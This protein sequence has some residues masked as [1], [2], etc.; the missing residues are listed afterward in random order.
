[1]HDHCLLDCLQLFSQ[2]AVFYWD[3][4]DTTVSSPMVDWSPLYK[5]LIKKMPYRF[6]YSLSDRGI[7]LIWGSCFQI[8]L[9]WIKLT[10]IKIKL[11][12]N[13]KQLFYDKNNLSYRAPEL[14]LKVDKQV[15]DV[16]RQ[17]KGFWDSD[18]ISF[19][20]LGN[21]ND[22]HFICA[23]FCVVLCF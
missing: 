15:V 7:F 19:L 17:R 10:K 23:S 14:Q 11:K 22:Q 3:T 21:K 9:A 16:K 8:S 6:V 20:D 4:L 12:R 1:M 18:N 5:K 2:L 13:N